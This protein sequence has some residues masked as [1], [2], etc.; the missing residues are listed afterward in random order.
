MGSSPAPFS[1]IG[2]SAK[3]IKSKI[4]CIT[5]KRF[6]FFFQSFI[7]I[8]AR[9]RIQNCYNN[10]GKGRVSNPGC[11]GE[12]PPTFLSSRILYHMLITVKDGFCLFVCFVLRLEQP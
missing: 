5:V 10:L 12:N 6:F 4:C 7:I 2:K 9:G 8:K 1:D 11:M 3:G